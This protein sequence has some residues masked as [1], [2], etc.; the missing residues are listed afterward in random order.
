M[1][2]RPPPPKIP[3]EPVKP[4]PIDHGNHHLIGVMILVMVITW[5]PILL[6]VFE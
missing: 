2:N 3:R 4:E 5:L 1:T 6:A